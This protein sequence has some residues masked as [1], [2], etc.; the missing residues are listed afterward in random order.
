VKAVGSGL[1]ILLLVALGTPAQARAPEDGYLRIE[2]VRAGSCRPA[3]VVVGQK[4]DCRFPMADPAL[5]LDPWGGPY[6][7][8]VDLPY[9]EMNDEQADCVIEGGELVCRGLDGYYQEGRR[10][11]SLVFGGFDRSQP[12]A[13]YEVIGGG[14][15]AAGINALTGGEPLVLPDRPLLVWTWSLDES[16][17]LWAAVYPRDGG[18][19][20]AMVPV[21]D[22]AGGTSVEVAFGSLGPGRYLLRACVGASP[23]SC[24]ESPGAT[25]FQIGSGDLV[26]AIPGWNLAGADRINLVL[27]GSGFADFE[28]FASIARDLLSTEGPLLLDGDGGTLPSIAPVEEVFG[29]EWG[30]FSVEPLRS[31]RRAFNLW[32]LADPVADPRALYHSPLPLGSGAVGTDGFGLDNVDI[33]TVHLEPFGRFRRSEAAWTSFDGREVLTRGAGLAF[34]GVYLALPRTYPLGEADTLLHELGHSL[35]GLRDEYSSGD[36]P[37]FYGYPNCASD[38]SVARG[39]W[40]D[41]IGEVDPF[42]EEY[43]SVMLRYQQ[44]LPDSLVA[45]LTVGYHRGGCYSMEE[46]A[47]R[48]TIESV[49]NGQTPVFGSVNRRRVEQVLG[50]FDGRAVLSDRSHVDAFECAVT[51][52]GTP[53]ALCRVSVVPFVDPPE[54]G[55]GIEVGGTRGTCLW[56][57]GEDASPGMVGCPAMALEGEG[58]WEV[59]LSPAEGVEVATVDLGPRPVSPVVVRPDPESGAGGSRESRLGWRMAGVAAGLAVAALGCAV[60]LGGRRRARRSKPVP[61]GGESSGYPCPTLPGGVGVTEEMAVKDAYLREVTATVVAV[62]DAGV[63]LDRTV[64]YPRGGG[65]PGDA[66]ILEWEGG[67]V[68]IRDTVRDAGVVLHVPA[69]DPPPVGTAVRAVVDWD[70]RHL[71][72]RTHTALHVLSSIVW[73]E[74]GAKVTGGNME[75]GQARMDFE[76][77]SMSAEFGREVETRLNRALA[78][79][80]AVRV[81][82][83]S[84]TEALADPDLIRTKV[85]L[86]P[87]HVDPIRIVDIGDVDR[88]ADG[89][90][91]VAD[92][93]EV[94]PVRV[95]KT[96][97][98]GKGNKRMRIELDP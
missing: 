17:Q 48:P 95:T 11:V 20:V 33:V 65:Q 60:A 68:A 72:M 56:L 62:T 74:Y 82:L 63:V 45:D 87:E 77:E 64:F 75:P 14:R 13:S 16:A 12:L 34:G 5:T 50:L 61:S 51:S 38:E 35:F 43:A 22:M 88:Q 6:V 10:S 3:E 19:R 98:K 52:L 26:E 85:S 78:E 49:M 46:E 86:I 96:E 84:R 30:P 79:G 69:A 73:R 76:L 70:R 27:A 21:P 97:S 40:G 1:V 37:V 18:S 89:G 93:R 55:L 36:R 28:S 94:G 31:A 7:A 53:L 4:V 58:P 29:L 9:D 80:H 25:Y 2:Q 54:G 81:F 71:L 42:V 67:A 39:W 66:G 24:Q 59:S 8:D 83:M 47:V 92:T 44:W 15:V 57:P 41:L 91:H 23:S 90:T 32:L